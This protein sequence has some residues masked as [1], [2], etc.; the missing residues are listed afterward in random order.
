MSL[1]LTELNSSSSALPQFP[2]TRVGG[3]LQPHVS[4]HPNQK[5][6]RQRFD[7]HSEWSQTHE[8]GIHGDQRHSVWHWVLGRQTANVGWGGTNRLRVFLKMCLDF[9][10]QII[11]RWSESC[12]FTFT[13]AVICH[14][15]RNQKTLTW[16]KNIGEII[17]LTAA[18]KHLKWHY[19]PRGLQN[20]VIYHQG[21]SIYFSL[22][23]LSIHSTASIHMFLFS[24]CP[25]PEQH[26][27]RDHLDAPGWEESGL[28]SHPRS[29]SPF[30]HV[31]WAGLWST[32]WQDTDYHFAGTHLDS[33]EKSRKD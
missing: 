31:Q 27:W 15:L 19:G 16:K 8:R 28:Q 6:A 2:D 3:T 11:C 24:L 13:S 29:P 4:G 5:A 10:V 23:R 32:L 17:F 20:K 30:F 18:F 12:L 25:A 14:V 9:S 1:F 22:D 7:G 33:K 26:A 21:Q